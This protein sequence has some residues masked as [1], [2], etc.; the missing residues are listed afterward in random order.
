MAKNSPKSRST[1]VE[2][3][4]SSKP[5]RKGANGGGRRSYA[6]KENKQMFCELLRELLYISHVAKRMGISPDAWKGEYNPFRP[7]SSLAYRTPEQ[8]AACED[9]KHRFNQVLYNPVSSFLFG[10][11]NEQGL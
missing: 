2:V 10:R 4:R 11:G 6:T 3:R 8:F 9:L 5:A 1:A 7:H